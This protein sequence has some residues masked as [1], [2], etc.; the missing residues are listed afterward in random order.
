[1]TTSTPDL[2]Q[3][4]LD[5][6]KSLM[7]E[8]GFTAVGLTE[9]LAAAKIPKGSFYHYFA[10]KEAFGDA[11]LTWYFTG[12]HAQLDVLLGGRDPA[13]QRLMRY[14]QYWLD[15]QTGDDPDQRCLAVK[16]SAEVAD[17]SESMRATLEWGTRGIIDRVMR[18][19]GEGK[20]DQSLQVTQDPAALAATLYQLWLG[21]SLMV[22]I[23]RNRGPLDTTMAS[24]RQ[25]LG[26]PDSP[27]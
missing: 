2:R 14:W 3:H 6:A 24:T 11:L 8:K 10:S 15:T 23:S 1:M 12:H 5:V 27:G 17:L 21:G 7:L 16:L 26:L 18:C 20:A 4:M 13:A 19:I 9:L 25:L 22:K